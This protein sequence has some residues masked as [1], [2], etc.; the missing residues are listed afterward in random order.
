MDTNYGLFLRLAGTSP[1]GSLECLMKW[2]PQPY[3][4]MVI[5]TAMRTWSRTRNPFLPRLRASSNIEAGKRGGKS[6]EKGYGSIGDQKLAGGWN[7]FFLTVNHRFLGPYFLGGGWPLGGSPLDRHD[8]RGWLGIFFF[9]H[10][11]PGKMIKF[12]EDFFR[13]VVQPPTRKWGDQEV[14]RW[15]KMG[16]MLDKSVDVSPS[17]SDPSFYDSKGVSLTKNNGR[18]LDMCFLFTL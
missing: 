11:L 12:D 16:M 4:F 1:V 7:I 5:G 13:W 17:K 3:G 15:S 8:T 10:P 18:F 6:G 9:V 14:Y 2:L